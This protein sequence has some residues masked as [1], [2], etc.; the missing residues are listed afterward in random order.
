[1]RLLLA[2]PFCGGAGE[3]AENSPGWWGA[4]CSNRACEVSPHTG[5]WRTKSKA[6]RGTVEVRVNAQREFDPTERLIRE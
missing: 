2:C 3:L 5:W 1:M 6:I 4:W